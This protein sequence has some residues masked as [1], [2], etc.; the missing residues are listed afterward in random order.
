MTTFALAVLAAPVIGIVAALD[1][2]SEGMRYLRA[3]S[4][5]GTR[6]ACHKFSAHA[7][8]GVQY[9]CEFVSSAQAVELGM[10]TTVAV[11]VLLGVTYVL[12][13]RRLAR[14]S[15][16]LARFAP[17]VIRAGLA[18]LVLLFTAQGG[19]LLWA[20]WERMNAQL[21]S[22]AA[23]LAVI[24]AGLIAAAAL[25]VASW[26]KLFAIEPLRIR[27]IV[28]DRQACPDL[29]ARVDQLSQQLGA[30][31]PKQLLL[32]LEPT[33]FVTTTAM[34][35]PGTGPLP[36]TET[37]YL[38]L[39]G[40]RLW[41]DAELKTRSSAMSSATSAAMIYVSPR[42][43]APALRSLA[44]SLESVQLDERDSGGLFR[45]ARL[46][47]VLALSFMLGTFT[48]LISSMRRARELIADRAGASVSSGEAL[49]SAAAKLSVL[50]TEW[51]DFWSALAYFVTMGRTRVNFSQDL[52]ERAAVVSNMLSPA[53]FTEWLLASRQPHPLDS[54]PPLAVRAAA[55][56]VDAPSILHSALTAL[57]TPANSSPLLRDLEEALSRIVTESIRIPGSKLVVDDTRGLPKEL[58]RRTP[59]D[60]PI[61][62]TVTN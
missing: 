12:V 3:S 57:R 43:L 51:R 49:I 56:M 29:W 52:I 23:W 55:L 25:I 4:A 16:R 6:V 20:L 46:P 35:L 13:V 15:D 22:G 28:A 53:Q 36:L 2:Q 60:R 59:A 8:A 41:S 44:V 58:A 26:R 31:S 33:A 19:L 50:E 34:A 24:G 38:P 14:S 45:A 48:A 30:A 54:H 37:L 21:T 39:G 7:A 5:S 11:T 18:V 9:A 1:L 40:L 61:A 62:A 47:A 32:G 10:V 17:G 42:A 27:A